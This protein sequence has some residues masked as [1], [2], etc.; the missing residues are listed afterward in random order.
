MI[1]YSADDFDQESMIKEKAVSKMS[2]TDLHLKYRWCLWFHMIDND[3]WDVKSY[4]MI[5]SFDNVCDFWKMNNNLPSVFHGMFFLMRDGIMPIY[6]DKNNVNGALYSF[7]IV[8]K[9]LQDVWNE[10]MICLVGHTL[11]PQADA[12]NGISVNPKSCVIKIWLGKCPLD[13]TKCE[14]TDQIDYLIPSRALY[15]RPQDGIKPTKR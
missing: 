15:L 11:Y 12:I 9:K 13:P 8:K 4:R 2:A 7:R 1:Y 3:S 14:I 5:Y 10:L 6:E